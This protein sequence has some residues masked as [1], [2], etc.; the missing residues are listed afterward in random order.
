MGSAGAEVATFLCGLWPKSG[1]AA[2]LAEITGGLTVLHRGTGYPC[3]TAKGLQQLVSI[4][5][6]G[7]CVRDRGHR[8]EFED[9]LRRLQSAI[10][11]SPTES[12]ASAVASNTT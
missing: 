10:L 2:T 3:L 4:D 7:M 8:Q 5:F 12:S 11:P 9:V 1:D 6:S